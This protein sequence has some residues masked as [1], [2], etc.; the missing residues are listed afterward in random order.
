MNRAQKMAWFTLIMLGLALGLS[1]AAVSVARFG[2][3]QPIR[4]AVGGFGFIGIMGFSGLAPVLFKKDKGKVQLDERDLMILRKASW[5]HT[6]FFG[7]S[8][9]LLL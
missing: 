5:W 9:C 4:R 3:G 7:F 6:R 2:F 1:L 8:L